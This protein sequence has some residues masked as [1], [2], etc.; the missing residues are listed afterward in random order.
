M[1][2]LLFKTHN[3]LGRYK[4]EKQYADYFE[5]L[6]KKNNYKY[7]REYK[8]APSFHGEKNGRNICD[9]IIEDK[10]VI[11]FKTVKFLTQE[12]YFQVKRYLSCSGLRLGILVNFRQNYLTPKRV[13]N[14]ELLK[15]LKSTNDIQIYEY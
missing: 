5:D 13:L 10:I 4:N 7:S 12:D 11:E 2:G 3:D 9:F 14:N 15:T 6:L 8:L 1:N